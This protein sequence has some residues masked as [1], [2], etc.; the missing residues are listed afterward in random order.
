MKPVSQGV[1]EGKVSAQPLESRVVEL[2]DGQLLLNGRS[3]GFL[4]T[5]EKRRVEARSR[6]AGATWASSGWAETF[7]SSTPCDTGFIRSRPR[8]SPLSISP[9]PLRKEGLSST[10]QSRPSE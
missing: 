1:D 4:E 10:I 6:D 7:P 3:V 8:A 2:A 5:G 9:E